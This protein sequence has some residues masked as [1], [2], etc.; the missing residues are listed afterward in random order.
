MNQDYSKS[1]SGSFT[2][3]LYL[4]ALEEG[5]IQYYTS[6]TIFQQDNARIHKSADV[7]EWFETYS[8]YVID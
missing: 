7:R 8:I 4:E 2:I 3:N 1:K 6:E 5:L